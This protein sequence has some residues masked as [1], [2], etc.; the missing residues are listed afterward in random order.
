MR[1]IRVIRRPTTSNKLIEN[2]SGVVEISIHCAIPC[3]SI[4]KVEISSCGD[5][6]CVPSSKVT[7]ADGKRNCYVQGRWKWRTIIVVVLF[8]RS[9][10]MINQLDSNRSNCDTIRVKNHQ[11]WFYATYRFSKFFVRVKWIECSEFRG[12]LTQERRNEDLLR[13]KEKIIFFRYLF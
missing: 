6:N 1:G 11:S 5:C 2:E 4:G 3:S 7:S 13:I 8:L 9:P 10:R 12:K